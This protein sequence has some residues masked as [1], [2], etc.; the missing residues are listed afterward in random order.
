MIKGCGSET[1]DKNWGGLQKK[2]K[3]QR[4]HGCKIYSLLGLRISLIVEM[5]GG[6]LFFF[7]FF[8][9]MEI[10]PIFV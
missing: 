8:F 3:D 2:K 5:T 4:P 9:F 10:T 7:F 6:D 1:E